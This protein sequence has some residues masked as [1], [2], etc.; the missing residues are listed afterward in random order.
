[1]ITPPNAPNIFKEDGS[2]NWENWIYDNPLAALE[3][4]QNIITENLFAN[5]GV[6]FNVL[7]KVNLKLTMGYSKLDSEEQL[8][9]YKEAYRPDLWNIIK[10]SMRNS[11]IKRQSWIVEPQIFYNNTIG[12]IN[13]DG[14]VGATFQNNKNSYLALE[15]SGYADKSLLR[16]FKSA[17]NIQIL[18]DDNT[19]Y[20][21]AAVFGRLGINL[22]R[23]YFLNITGRR[24]GSSRFGPE[25]RF[26]NFWA[27]GGAWIFIDQK[28]DNQ[29]ISPF[30]FGK[31]RASYG[32]TGSDQI[33]DYGYLDAYEA[34]SGSGGLYPTQ[35]FNPNYSWEVNKKLEVA[36]Q[37]SLFK[38]HINLDVSWFKNRSA[39][40]LV[41]FPLPA[42]TGFTS[43]QANLPALVQNTGLELQWS[44][45][46]I[47]RKD[48][49]WQ[50]SFNITLP[51]NKLLKFDRIEQTS[52]ANIYK[53][54]E[55]LNISHRYKFNGINSETGFYSMIDVN[56]DGRLNNDDRIVIMDMGRKYF[57]GFSNTIRY[58][59]LSL[60]FLF[61][62]VKQ[63]N[64]SY[65]FKWSAPG[66]LGNKP[67]Q[68]LNSWEEPG[69]SEDIQKVS[70]SSIASKAFNDAANS[71]K[72][73]ED[74]SF[75]RLKNVALSYQFPRKVIKKLGL[76]EVNLYLNAQ[77]LIT[78]TG[79]KGLDPQGG[80]GVVPPLK[81][82][83]CGL[84]ITL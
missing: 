77:N 32:I 63:Y 52:Y 80:R 59:E 31:L 43:V 9:F 56:G 51:E 48:F 18:S 28:I 62:Y 14:L 21:Y 24:D 45:K 47:N 23:K 20:R 5:L 40:Q 27:V 66:R 25:S 61:E 50:S 39:N 2:L 78:L 44:S 76:E 81:T 41:G 12:K 17:D 60:Q 3:Q 16:N 79:Y 37:F 38:D 46:N 1:M 34:T 69:D 10:L 74:A 22:N 11:F 33:E 19:Q 70:L 26:S 84:Q 36:I 73:I 29:K 6:L 13:L 35:L 55:P 72:G 57:G 53:V 4:P 8:R 15:G 75:L 83:T 68:F 42:I 49:S 67:L 30:S 7:P 54:G 71:S 82:I 58:K 65:I 64:Q